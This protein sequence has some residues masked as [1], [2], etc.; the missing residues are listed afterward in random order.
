MPLNKN[1]KILG[2]V[3]VFSFSWNKS[4]QSASLN[5]DRIHP[6]KHHRAIR[7]FQG[8][9]IDILFFF[10]WSVRH[11]AYMHIHN[12]YHTIQNVWLCWINHQSQSVT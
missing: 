7:K 8:H 6:N 11:H 9:L 1:T 12:M 5:N 4:P 10:S 3:H 2:I